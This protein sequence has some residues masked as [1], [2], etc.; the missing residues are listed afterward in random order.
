MDLNINDSQINTLNVCLFGAGAWGLTLANLLASKGNPCVVWD[1]DSNKIKQLQKTHHSGVPLNIDLN[2]S[3]RF[4]TDFTTAV[5]EVQVIVSVVPSFAV[6]SI[7]ESLKSLPDQLGDRLFISCSKGIEEETL[8]LP[9]MIFNEIL[10][11]TLTDKYVVLSGP[12][13]AEEVSRQIPTLITASSLNKD[14]ALFAQRLFMLPTF[15]IYTNDDVIGVEM[16]AAIKN[17]IAI[18]AGMSDGLKYGDNTKAALIT[19]ALAEM[20]RALH[21]MGGDK[22]TLSG[23]AGLGDLVVTTMSRHSRNRMFGQLLAEGRTPA[24][25][26]K[27]VGAVVEGYKTAYSVYEL[28]KKLHVDMPISTLVYKVCYE[29][30]P[31]KDAALALLT[32]EPKPEMY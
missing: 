31:L 29:N 2:Q 1:I 6:R 13:H 32:R 26:L 17:V 23:L 18:A 5:K 20:S 19:R 22:E 27:E 11:K 25:A 9:S 7:C 30:Y 15:R 24:E 12:T 4:E 16:G 21:L 10:G 14:A 28:S 8:L 3:I